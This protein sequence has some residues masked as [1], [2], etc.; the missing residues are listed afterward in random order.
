LGNVEHEKGVSLYLHSIF[1]HIYAA[2]IVRICTLHVDEGYFADTVGGSGCAYRV[3]AAIKLYI[4]LSRI[5][6]AYEATLLPHV[7]ADAAAFNYRLR[8]ADFERVHVTPT[9]TARRLHL[10]AETVERLCI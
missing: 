2:E 1:R 5:S 9:R 8:K 4:K 6:S 10:V 7:T 3:T